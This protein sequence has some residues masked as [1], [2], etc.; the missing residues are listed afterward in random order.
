VYAL[1]QARAVTDKMQPPARPLA[2]GTHA[3]VG[4]PD[5]G[6][7]VPTRQL[8][9]DP[10]VDAV[11]LARQRRQPFHLLRVG[12]LHLPALKLESVVH[13][14]SPVHRLDRGADRLVV[15]GDALAQAAQTVGIRRRRSHLHGR[16]LGVEEME[17]E[18]LATEIQT[19]V[20]H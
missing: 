9:E 5:R 8:G 15:H 12:D 1:L 7:Q 13:E 14:A 20:Q 16:T 18:T 6:H 4:Q 17:V 11:G 3:R 2:L 10:G 19:D